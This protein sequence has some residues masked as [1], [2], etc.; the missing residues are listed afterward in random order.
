MLLPA[1]PASARGQTKGAALTRDSHTGEHLPS[2]GKRAIIAILVGAGAAAVVA[3]RAP[4][5]VVPLAGWI[6]AATLWI[7]WVTGSIKGLDSA[8]C[9]RLATREDSSRAAADLLLLGAS[10]SSLAAVLLSLLKA[11]SLHGG[12]KILLTSI[13]LASVVVS[14]AVVHFVFMLRYAR[15]YFGP[16]GGRGIN[17]H[18]GRRERTYADF[19]YLA[20]TVGMT[21]QVSDTEINS[22][23]IRSSVLRHA[24]LSFVFG[25]TIIALTINVVAGLAK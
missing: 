16:E 17:F 18:D 8:D 1:A 7:A 19:A 12:A 21:Y 20:F 2:A 25:T 13:C 3:T 14:W 22:R 5:Q 23:A 24:L 11:S 6:C 15:L 9:A 4:W 10:T